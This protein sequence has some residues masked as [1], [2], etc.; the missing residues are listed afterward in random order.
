[1]MRA[2][3]ARRRCALA[4]QAALIFCVFAGTVHAQTALA[5]CYGRENGQT[6]TAPGLPYNPNGL[7]AAH[8]TLPF[9]TLL[10]VGYHNRSVVVRINDRGPF[11]KGRD[12]DLSLGACRALGLSLGWVSVEHVYSPRHGDFGFF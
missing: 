3:L 1:M 8:K 2:I 10:R 6:R 9:G 4:W 12:L 7:T 11:V 5:S